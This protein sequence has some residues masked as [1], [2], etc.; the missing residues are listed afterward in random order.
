MSMGSLLLSPSAGLRSAVF[1]SPHPDDV[2]L[3]CGILLARLCRQS[4]DIRYICITD[5]APS[6]DLLASLGRLPQHYDRHLYQWRRRSETNAALRLIGVPQASVTFLDYPDLLCAKY[7]SHIVQDLS[8]LI[9][10][11][12][13]VFCCPFE[14][15]HPDHDVSRLALGVAAD[16][17]QYKGAIVEYASYNH[18]GHNVFAA[19][20]PPSVTVVA[21]I[22]EQVL[23]R[24]VVRAFF[25][26]RSI[27]RHFPVDRESFRE[28]SYPFK[29]SDFLS[30]PAPPYYERFAYAGSCV[31]DQIRDYMNKSIEKR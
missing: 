26:Q 23:Q 4:V 15:G 19:P 8:R 16:C 3:C 27:A 12:D 30:Y 2:E 18:R 24:A 31:L 6:P 9:I 29:F 28:V 25:S 10:S 1:L 7:V 20:T 11:A 14:G 21:T 22:S 5:G 13:A 17:I